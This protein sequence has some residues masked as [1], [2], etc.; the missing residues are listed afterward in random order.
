MIIY[1]SDDL[2]IA[3]EG[4][5]RIYVDKSKLPTGVDYVTYLKRE[6][7]S[8]AANLNADKSN[9]NE[10]PYRLTEWSKWQL[11]REKRNKLLAESDWTQVPDAPLTTEQKQAWRQYRQEL[12]DI[13]Q[14]FKRA[15]DVVW[16]IP[17]S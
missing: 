3:E 7:D 11:V 8:V 5:L 12:R 15:D 1:E 13:P 10:M 16:P 6:L 2:Y 14:R 4:A 9:E 17:P